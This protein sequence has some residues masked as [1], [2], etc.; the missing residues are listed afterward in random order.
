VENSRAR[1]EAIAESEPTRSTTHRQPSQ[2]AWIPPG[3][4]RYETRA[5]FIANFA[6]PPTTQFAYRHGRQAGFHGHERLSLSEFLRTGADHRHPESLYRAYLR[7]LD[8]GR[9]ERRNYVCRRRFQEASA[10][11]IDLLG[12]GASRD[13][14]SRMRSAGH[15]DAADLWQQELD[16]IDPAVRP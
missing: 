14:I 4:R 13:L 15:S 10:I 5:E 6:T 12:A 9:L 8:A 7:G 2:A 11:V 3:H 1:F 16:R